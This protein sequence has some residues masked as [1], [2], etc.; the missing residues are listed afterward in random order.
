MKIIHSYSLLFTRAKKKKEK[1]FTRVLSRAVS[2]ARVRSRP[3]GTRVPTASSARLSAEEETRAARGAACPCGCGSLKVKPRHAA[4]VE[5]FD[6]RGTEP[7]EPFEFF[8]NRNFPNFSLEKQILRKF[9]NFRKC[10]HCSD[11]DEILSEF[12][13]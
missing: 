11:F 8:Q 3:S 2:W 12:R 1:R 5:R 4:W 13:R 7:F 9:K 6:R 10:Q